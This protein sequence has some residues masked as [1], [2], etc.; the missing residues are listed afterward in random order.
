MI[1]FKI[2][3]CIKDIYLLRFWVDFWWLPSVAEYYQCEDDQNK[4]QKEKKPVTL[5]FDT[6]DVQS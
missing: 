3:I 5:A 4:L 1:I 2:E 6:L